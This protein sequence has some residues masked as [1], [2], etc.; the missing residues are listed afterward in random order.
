M[1]K[2]AVILLCQFYA[3][4]ARSHAG[5]RRAAGQRLDRRP[6]PIHESYSVTCTDVLQSHYHRCFAAS[7][8]PRVYPSYIH[9]SCIH[10]SYIHSSYTHTSYIH[11]SYI[12]K[13]IRHFSS[14]VCHFTE[15]FK[16]IRGL[17]AH[18]YGPAAGSFVATRR[19]QDEERQARQ[20][21]ATAALVSGRVD[22]ERVGGKRARGRDE[23]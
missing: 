23:E 7:R 12:R 11:T 14:A 18:L 4:G 2:C 22:R 10:S 17:H 3:P 5:A 16:R 1:R 13:V 19:Q 15:S 6:S 21:E 20:L 9:S 8:P